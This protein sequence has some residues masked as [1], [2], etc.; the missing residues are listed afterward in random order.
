MASASGPST[1]TTSNCHLQVT[2][3]KRV[4][5]PVATNQ[6]DACHEPKQGATPY[7]AGPRH[8][9]KRAGDNPELCYACHDRLAETSLV[10]QPVKMGVCILCHD[11]HGAEHAMFLRVETD[12]QLCAQC[13]RA[14]FDQGDHVH[15]PVSDGTCRACHNPHGS[16]HKQLLHAA[17]PEL[18]L[19]CH[20]TIEELLDDATV[21][22]DVVT[23]GQACL[24]C[25]DPHV[26]GA[27]HLLL[28]EPMALC[29]SC[30]DQELDSGGG[31]IRNI[32]QHLKANPNHHGPTRDENC[33]A[34][35]N[36]HGGM[37]F[38][39]LTEAYPA[40]LLGPFDEDRYA[41]CFGCHELEMVEEERD[42]EVTEFRNGDLNLHYVHV[43]REVE[44]SACHVCH[45]AHAS[46]NPKHIVD[47]GFL[48]MGGIQMAY[49][50][51]ATGGSCR[52]ECHQRKAYDRDHPVQNERVRDKGGA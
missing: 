32:A 52:S 36:P 44:G 3:N 10:H 42:E 29:L 41:L 47:P 37:F 2:Q 24:S 7:E 27:K 39:L 13:H 30:H 25:H 20:D 18:C 1:C 19:D 35:H 8:E 40:D 31:K 21:T 9:F 22:H 5:E 48:G 26:S 28:G 12:R 17:P 23:T 34:C 45:D 50:R 14:T 51:S 15:P 49:E 6:C 33:S 11:P 4:H 16:D 38:R 46:K 43:N